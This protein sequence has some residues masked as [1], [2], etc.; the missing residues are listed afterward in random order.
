MN[1]FLFERENCPSCGNTSHQSI[2]KYD[3][4]DPLVKNFMV[5]EYGE[6]VDYSILKDIFLE[7]C[8]CNRCELGFQKV[9]FKEECLYKVYDEWLDQEE[10]LEDHLKT[11][12]WKVD[13][14]R[15]ILEFVKSFLGKDPWDIK[16][17]DYGAGFGE[18]LLMGKKMGFD[19][20]A[21]EYSKERINYLVNNQINVITTDDKSTF[22]FIILDQVLEHSTFPDDILKKLYN[23]LNQNGL[24]YI[25]VPNC[26]SFEKQ[27]KKVQS[28]LNKIESNAAFRAA[29][30][31]PFS[32][33][34]FFNNSSLRTIS[35]ANGFEIIFP[36]KKC[37]IRPVSIKSFLRPF[38]NYFFGTVFFLKK[39]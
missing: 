1:N 4:N 27:L 23:K 20:S 21:V 35:K 14:N 12:M 25:A 39:V 18:S 33:L 32:H 15:R 37:L 8:V 17:L 28:L 13:Y 11:G 30:I 34:N 19:T 36:F 2:F 9:V 3:F 6:R 16:F 24:V 26:N 22:D 31:G 38:Y 7:F 10:A 5:D 29:S